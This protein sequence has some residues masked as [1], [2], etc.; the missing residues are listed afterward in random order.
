VASIAIAVVVVI[1]AVFL[2]SVFF[3]AIAILA[4]LD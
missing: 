3:N 1:D 4:A 2:V